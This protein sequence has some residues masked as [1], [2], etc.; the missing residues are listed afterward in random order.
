MLRIAGGCFDFDVDE[1][2]TMGCFSLGLVGIYNLLM[3]AKIVKCYEGLRQDILKDYASKYF[4][5]CDF[6]YSTRNMLHIHQ[7]K[8]VQHSNHMCQHRRIILLRYC[9]T[10]FA[11]FFDAVDLIFVV[12]SV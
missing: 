9:Y 6:I 2:F 7:V 5:Q 10:V 11:F 8:A 1:I 3:E 4:S 12:F